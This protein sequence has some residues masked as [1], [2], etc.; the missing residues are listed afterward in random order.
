M[1]HNQLIKKVEVFEK[2][3]LYG[4][5]SSFLKALAQSVDSETQQVLQQIK[6]TLLQANVKN[7]KLFNLLNNGIMFPSQGLK[8]QEII[9]ALN[10]LT[11][12]NTNTT[13]DDALKKAQQ[14]A[15]QLMTAPREMPAT[16]SPSTKSPTFQVTPDQQRALGKILTL[17]GF[18]VPIK[19]DGIFGPETQQALKLF[20]EKVLDNYQNYTDAEALHW[21]EMLMELPQYKNSPMFE[22]DVL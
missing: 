15:Q 4:D 1:K 14:L 3:A 5:R 13:A 21:A 7:E 2:L 20:K 11:Y 17:K 12:R 6:D 16:V 18:G 8:A 10:N 22:E 9:T 19:T